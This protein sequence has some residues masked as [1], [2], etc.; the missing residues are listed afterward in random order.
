MC[1]ICKILFDADGLI[2]MVRRISSTGPLI[3]HFLGDLQAC[4]KHLYNKSC[5]HGGSFSELCELG[6]CVRSWFPNLRSPGKEIS[7][8]VFAILGVLIFLIPIAAQLA[9]RFLG[10]LSCD[11][12]LVETT[13]YSKCMKTPERTSGGLSLS[14]SK[15]FAT[16]MMVMTSF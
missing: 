5:L 12:R 9:P 3:G 10:S 11:S 8:D 14:S 2:Q 7:S 15:W 16:C 13:T 4:L 6:V 1:Q